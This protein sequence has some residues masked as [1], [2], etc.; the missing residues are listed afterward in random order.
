MA[1]ANIV[2][3]YN[4][5]TGLG[6]SKLVCTATLVADAAAGGNSMTVEYFAE[7]TG[8]VPASRVVISREDFLAL[9]LLRAMP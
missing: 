8:A 3:V 4:Q 2:V 5:P 9:R 6:T 7:L 1:T